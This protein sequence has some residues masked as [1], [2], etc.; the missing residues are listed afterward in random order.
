MKPGTI[1]GRAFNREEPGVLTAFQSVVATETAVREVSGKM[2]NLTKTEPL[3]I[4]L[5]TNRDDGIDNA[6]ANE[7]SH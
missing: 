3:D 6:N 7:V 1:L 4:L 2:V 5:T